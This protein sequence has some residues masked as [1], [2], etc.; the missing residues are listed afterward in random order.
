MGG[1]RVYVLTFSYVIHFFTDIL[2]TGVLWFVLIFTAYCVGGW[3]DIM[4]THHHLTCEYW[5]DLLDSPLNSDLDVYTTHSLPDLETSGLTSSSLSLELTKH[6][7]HLCPRLH[8]V[9]PLDGE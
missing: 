2:A 3:L 9:L 7:R 4:M 6:F 8:V 1:R 5:I